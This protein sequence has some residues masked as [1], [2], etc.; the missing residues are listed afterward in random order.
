MSQTLAQAAEWV[1]AALPL[2]F[3]NLRKTETD[4]E[5]LV[6]FAHRPRPGKA[7]ALAQP[8]HRFEALNGPSRCVE[9]L[10]AANPRHRPLD[11][12][13]IALDPLLQV[14]G[15]VMPDLNSGGL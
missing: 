15:D 1:V 6:L 13:V 3:V 14:L 2:D 11:S 8:Q 12:E 4:R 7:G 5:Q 10:K 9:G